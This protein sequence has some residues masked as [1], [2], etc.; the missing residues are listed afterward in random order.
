M[1]G[2][3]ALEELAK[4][5]KSVVRAEDVPARFGGEEF[6]VLLV[7]CSQNS[8][9]SAAE[10]I[11]ESIEK[12]EIPYQDQILNISVSIGVCFT[13]RYLQYTSAEV[14]DRADK[15]LYKSKKNGRNQTT[16]YKPGL[17]FKARQ[18]KVR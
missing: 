1:A 9:W 13:N 17:Y 5:L 11:R 2:D 3:I 4:A 15:A 6:V 8:A 14:I 18:V 10:R 12:L 16:L 7:N